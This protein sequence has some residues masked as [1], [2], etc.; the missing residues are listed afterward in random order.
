MYAFVQEKCQVQVRG[1]GAMAHNLWS[2]LVNK[3]L[4]GTQL[5]PFED[6]LIQLQSCVTRTETE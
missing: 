2:V 6:I 1:W 4:I 5:C 3:S